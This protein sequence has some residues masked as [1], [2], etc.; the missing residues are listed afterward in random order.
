MELTADPHFYDLEIKRLLRRIQLH[1]KRDNLIAFY[2]SSSIRLW[3]HMKEDLN[4]LNTLNLGFGGSSF[5][6][7]IHHFPTLFAEIEPSE[8][9]VYVGDNDLGR[10]T[11]KEE[12][13][14]RYRALVRT[15]RGKYPEILIHFISVKPSPARDYLIPTIKWV[16]A[17]I[18][19][20]I[21]DSENMRYINIYDGMLSNGHQPDTSYYI[22]DQLHL[23]RRGYVVWRKILRAHFNLD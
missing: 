19:A 18:E 10:G 3:V 9:V 14:E 7:C 13:M 11:P 12:V 8:I 6:W 15:I 1:Q 21:L 17:R 22:S 16:N 2:G 4:P 20:E 23:N 5:L